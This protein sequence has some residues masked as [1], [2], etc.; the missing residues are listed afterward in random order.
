MLSGGR[1]ESPLLPATVNLDDMLTPGW[2]LHSTVVSLLANILDAVTC[3]VDVKFAKM[4]LPAMLVRLAVK[5]GIEITGS[6][7]RIL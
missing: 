5:G 2:F 7:M 3:R 6:V 1:Q 4:P